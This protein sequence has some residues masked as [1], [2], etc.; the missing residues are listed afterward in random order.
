MAEPDVDFVLN[1][2]NL[3]TSFAQ[4]DYI[5]EGSILM[6]SQRRQLALKRLQNFSMSKSHYFLR[7]ELK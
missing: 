3:E 2:E 4:Q 1:S 6:M 5:S 7:I